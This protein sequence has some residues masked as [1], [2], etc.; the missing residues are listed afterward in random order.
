[1]HAYALRYFVSTPMSITKN[2]HTK[3]SKSWLIVKKHMQYAKSILGL[4]L[5]L[6][7]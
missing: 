1:M 6:F 5:T 3:H 2:D 4:E 7:S